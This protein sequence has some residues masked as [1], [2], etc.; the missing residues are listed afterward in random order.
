[1]SE[2]NHATP[3]PIHHLE[4][5]SRRM[6]LKRGLM[7]AGALAFAITASPALVHAQEPGGKTVAQACADQRPGR[8]QRPRDG[9]R[10]GDGERTP[11]GK[12]ARNCGRPRDGERTRDGQRPE[13]GER[14]QGGGA[15]QR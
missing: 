5:R 7:F 1:M 8:G 13:R 10:A 2:N 11:G 14:P 3:P 6:L 15:R 4:N 12:R 9:Q